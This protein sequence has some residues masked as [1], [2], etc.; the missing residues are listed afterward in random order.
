[1]YF[2]DRKKID[3][4]LDYMESLFPLIDQLQKRNRA[5]EELAL[6]R[7]CY[8]LIESII[9][10]G[11]SIIDGFIMRDPGSYADIVDILIDEKVISN[12]HGES[13]KQIVQCRKEII[14]T[15]GTIDH[16]NLYDLLCTHWQALTA[17][18]S[19]VRLYVENELGPVSAF[20]PKTD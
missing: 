5:I 3:E 6:E 7:V 18:P 11:N 4:T 9:D 20:L 19:K 1:M 13:L 10:V 12:E 17:F 8:L 16:D 14:Q 2:V 15:T